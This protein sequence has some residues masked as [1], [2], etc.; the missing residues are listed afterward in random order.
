M[1]FKKGRGVT[2][3]RYARHIDVKHNTGLPQIGPRDGLASQ[4]VLKLYDLTPFKAKPDLSVL[5]T[6]LLRLELSVNVPGI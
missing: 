3:Y 6:G 2:K 5:G 1:S 4:K